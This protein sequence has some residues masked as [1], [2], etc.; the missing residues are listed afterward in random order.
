MQETST[1]YQDPAGHCAPRDR[2]SAHT[3]TPSGGDGT[4]GPGVFVD[5]E[6]KRYYDFSAYSAKLTRV[7]AIR[8]LVK[9]MRSRP[10]A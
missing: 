4:Q 10:P 8:A 9:V 3:T 1:P 5:V 7:T 2:W 6:G